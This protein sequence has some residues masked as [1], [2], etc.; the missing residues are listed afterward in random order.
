[1]IPSLIGALAIAILV[2]VF[3]F[4]NGEPVIVRLFHA[5]LHV[6]LGLALVL[7]AAAGAAAGT[8]LSLAALVRKGLTIARLRRTADRPDGRG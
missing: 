3:A 4:Q 6:S 7:A 2:A 5:Q 8:L 1:M